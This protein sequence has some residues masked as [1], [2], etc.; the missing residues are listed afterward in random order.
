LYSLPLTL[1][2]LFALLHPHPLCPFRPPPSSPSLPFSP[3]F[4]ALPPRPTSSPS[5]LALPPGPPPSFPP[6][7]I[8]RIRDYHIRA[9]ELSSGYKFTRAHKTK[10]SKEAGRE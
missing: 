6:L 9:S 2:A 8:N 3:Y 1:F 5:L 7:T 10:S 4:L